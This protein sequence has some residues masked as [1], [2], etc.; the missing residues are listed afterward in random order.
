MDRGQWITKWVKTSPTGRKYRAVFKCG[1]C[2]S[3]SE[4]ASNY[5]ADCGDPKNGD[6]LISQ[7]R[8]L[9]L[10]GN[11]RDIDG[12]KKG[13]NVSRRAVIALIESLQDERETHETD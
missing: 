12:Y 6:Q 9:D 2:G 10:I 11:M 5:C 13:D 4:T 1:A 8:A 3:L 7:Q